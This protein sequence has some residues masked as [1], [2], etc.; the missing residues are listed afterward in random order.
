M[1]PTRDP[2]RESTLAPSEA[3]L[4]VSPGLTDLG[5]RVSFMGVEVAKGKGGPLTPDAK[6]FEKDVVTEWDL[7]LMQ[8]LAV[9]LE[10][11][12]SILLEGGSG[13]GKSSTVDRMCGYLQ[14]DVYYAN[15]AEYDIDTLIG[16]KTIG[17]DGSVEWRDGI[18]TKWLRDGGVL[19]LDEYNFMR[20]EVRG[21]LHE[22]L[23]SVLRGTG[24]VSLTENYG[25]QIKVHPD[26]RLIAAQ[27]EPGNDQSDRQVLDA[28]QLTRFVYIKEV[29]DLPKEVKLARALGAIGED[30]VVTLKPEDYLRTAREP[31]P[32]RDIPGIKD[33]ISRYVEFADSIEQLVKTRQ[34]G[35]GQPQPVYF[36][37]SR[38]QKRVFEFVEKF[39][40]GD[41]NGTFQKALRHYYKN[42]FASDTDRE[43]I[44][45]LIKLV[46]TDLSSLPSKR[47]GLD[48]DTATQAGVSAAPSSL[49]AVKAFLGKN[50]LGP[51]EWKAQGIDVGDVPPIPTS[52]TKKLLESECPL[53]P[54][55]KIKDTHLLV[56]VP[57]T[58]NGEP[59]TPLKL[60]ELCATRK[61]SGGR[62]IYADI[63]SWKSQGWASA[64]QSRS[65]WV[66]LPK[67]DPDPGV[68][69]EKYGEVEGAKRHF[70]SKRIAEQETVH[71][72]Y[73][74]YREVKT[75]ELMTVVL[76]HDLVNKERLLPDY[77]RCEESNAS[78][79][80]VCVG[81]F[82]AN[83][84]EVDDGNDAYAYDL[85]GRALARKTI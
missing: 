7:K 17:K 74:D 76:L 21:R 9:G 37:S 65:E 29:E 57:K 56:L 54:G 19:F 5:D 13:I 70:R 47:K 75:V 3:K 1:E 30:N 26:C 15:C 55:E 68:M 4:P 46:E 32:L 28:P 22:V 72:L 67:S 84:L 69:Q 80:R 45:H 64:P 71:K 62:L 34:A 2:K 8:K 18:V 61:G 81:D 42:K 85:I 38:D 35:K 52:I 14:R 83:G 40:D 63:D 50:F 41:P 23:D 73:P 78:G 82:V 77:L 27:N 39:F 60:E 53:H 31:T 36:S 49:A 6:R 25:E 16:S 51:E 33:L 44:E 58:V 11:N 20:G 12:Q 48:P 59:Y 10:L 66:L 79:G 24:T 43:K